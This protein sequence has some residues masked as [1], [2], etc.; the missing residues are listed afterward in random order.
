MTTT[1]QTR[2]QGLLGMRKIVM[3]GFLTPLAVGVVTQALKV[4]TGAV[5]LQFVLTNSVF[6]HLD[7]PSGGLNFVA[8]TFSNAFIFTWGWCGLFL[9]P[10]MFRNA[11]KRRMQVEVA[12]REAELLR[13]RAHLEP[14]FLLNT[15]NTVSGLVVDDPA[16]ARRMIGLLGDLLRDA[17]SERASNVHTLA[18]EIAW[19]ERYAA[20]H[21]SRHGRMVCFAWDVEPAAKS[22]SVPRLVLQPLVENAVL[23]GILRHRHGGT[24]KVRAYLEGSDLVCDV[25]D[26]GPGFPPGPRRAGAQGLRIVQRTLA[27]FSRHASLAIASEQG[28]TRVTARLPLQEVGA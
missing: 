5:T 10:V 1:N 14:H 13:L 21:E 22:A 11:Q 25:E 19:L 15:L 26:D 20:I 4:W 17:T 27:L 18:E 28:A 3:F 7:E 16:E 6:S 8:W 24:V 23:H 2:A 9:L 12:R